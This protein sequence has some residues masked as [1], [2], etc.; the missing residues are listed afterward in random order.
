MT[1]DPELVTRKLL[2]MASDLDALRAFSEQGLESYLVSRINQAVV[3]RCLERIIGR[4]ID[5]NYHLLTTAG[6]PP[7]R[8]TM[9]HSCG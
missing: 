8:T 1:I 4:M 6:Q 2:L 5:V 7:P 9:R 3:E